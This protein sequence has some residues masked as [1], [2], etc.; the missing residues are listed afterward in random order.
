[1]ATDAVLDVECSPSAV[2]HPHLG[3]R[4]RR[5]RLFE[6]SA[7]GVFNALLALITLHHEMWRDELQAWLIARD[8]HSLPQLLHALHYEGHPALWYLLLW[9]PSHF[10]PNPAGMQV[11]NFF[12]S[13][14]LAWLILTA[15]VLPPSTRLLIVFSYFVFYQYG[16]TARSY[17]L[18]VL[19][20]IAAT[21][22]LAG[23]KQHRKLAILLLA[24]SIN[25]HAFAAPV[26]VVLAA[27]AFYFAKLKTRRDAAR[28]LGDREFLAAF[29]SLA[30]SGILAAITVWPAKDIVGPD[31]LMPTVARD[32]QVSSSMVWLAFV[33]R[34]PAP[35]HILLR[36]IHGLV[37]VSCLISAVILV[38]AVLLL[39]SVSARIFFLLCALMEIA[40]MALTVGWPS[41]YHL[42]FI[43]AS[44]I[45][46]L[47][48]DYSRVPAPA[49]CS[50]WLS[51]RLTSTGI[52]LLLLPQV[53]CCADAS[54]LDWMRPYSDAKEVS[55]WMKASHLEHNPLV[56]QPSEF[57]SGI[58]ADLE[59][60]DAYYPSC[61]C[62]GSYE[63]RNTSRSLYR[64]ATAA[65]L[66]IARGTS[67]LPVIL[68]SNRRLLPA[69]MDTLGLVQIYAAQPNSLDTYEVFFVYEQLHPPASKHGDPLR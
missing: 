11:V 42:G 29:F 26:A 58:V 64:T 5:A 10:S 63:V 66:K 68:I 16:V 1:M 49:P 61:R 56:L 27:S 60:P 21:R 46:A 41:G 28:L 13:I 48:F 20:L 17:G 55:G 62:Y 30:I 34:V 69:Q 32:F 37:D 44:F 38:V 18:A 52:F 51:S 6:W 54:A 36:H 14:G 7:F 35:V 12:I 25:T 40:T 31:S 3:A 67:P 24:L 15:R 47:I 19:L 59:R 23:E 50:C 33:P 65:D 57:T 39:R 8:T 43:F 45:I 22:C 9:I 2:T 53:L 4:G